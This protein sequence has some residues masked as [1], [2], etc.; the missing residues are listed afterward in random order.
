[1][2][3]WPSSRAGSCASWNQNALDLL[4]RGAEVFRSIGFTM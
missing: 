4:D 2:R 3:A 1:M